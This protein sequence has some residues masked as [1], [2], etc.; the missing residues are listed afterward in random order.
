MLTVDHLSAWYGAAQALR[1]VSLQVGAGE[2][3]TIVGRNGA[4]KTT[5]LRCLMGLHR[6][7]RGTVTLAGTDLGGLPAHKRAR[8]GLGWVPDDRG[9]YASLS[10]EEHLMLPPRLGGDGWSLDRVYETFPILRT[11]RKVAGTQL[12]GGEQQILAIAR[13][14]RSGAPLLLCDEPTE[15]L[16]PVIVE[17]IGAALAEIKRQG[18]TV[19]LIEQ[20]VRFASTIADRHYLL[21]QGHVVESL[22]NTEV[23]A[24]ER[25]LLTHLGI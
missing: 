16:A 14:L 5:L 12:S 18:G 10:V 6:Q 9:T 21:A 7:Q 23:R 2:V 19:L 22:D 25:E 20:N 3:V 1:E 15:G 4:G 13:A 24:R 11:R 8:L 17:R